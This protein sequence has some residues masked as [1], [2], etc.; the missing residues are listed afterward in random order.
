MDKA[1]LRREMKKIIKNI[2][3]DDKT[4]QDKEIFSL[5]QDKLF[6]KYKN[7]AVYISLPDEVDTQQIIQYI[8]QTKRNCLLPIQHGDNFFFTQIDP[9]TQY[10]Q[11]AQWIYIPTIQN[12]SPIVPDAILI[13][14]LAF[15]KQGLRLGKWLWR[16]DRLLAQYPDSVKIALSYTQQIQANIPTQAH[17]QVM[18]MILSTELYFRP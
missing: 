11:N 13:P 10:Q 9:D 16:Y 3:L 1:S 2:S 17:D 4:Q 8:H 5:R 15:T 6:S 18:D 12:P 7:R 14:G